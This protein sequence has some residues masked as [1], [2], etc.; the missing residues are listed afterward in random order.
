MPRLA[1]QHPAI[2]GVFH[3]RGRE[4]ALR[5]R[6]ASNEVS[7]LLVASKQDRFLA[8]LAVTLAQRGRA[9]EAV[10]ALATDPEVNLRSILAQV[11]LDVRLGGLLNRTWW[12]LRF[13]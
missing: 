12:W 3:R 13:S 6:D 11:L 5:P 8:R 10:A 4:P 9:I 2:P 1:V 7:L